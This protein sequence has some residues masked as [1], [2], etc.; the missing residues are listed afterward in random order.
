MRGEF[1]DRQLSLSRQAQLAIVLFLLGALIGAIL[2]GSRA[3]TQGDQATP[4]PA[5]SGS[6][7]LLHP[8]AAQWASLSLQPVALHDFRDEVT[9][10]GRIAVNEDRST[11]IFSPYSGLVKRLLVKP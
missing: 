10:D 7:R 2:L 9:T 11:P 5:R 6:D 3:R 4:Q 1:S 8:T